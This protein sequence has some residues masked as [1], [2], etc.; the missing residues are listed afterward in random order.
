[1]NTP[2]IEIRNLIKYYDNVPVI[3]SASLT[4]D[5]GEILGITG[6][7]DSAKTTFVN[8]LAGIVAPDSGTILFNGQEV[9]ILS[10]KSA[11]QAGVFLISE[12]S[13]GIANLNAADNLFWGNLPE[14]RW[15]TYSKKKLT[16]RC[17]E[18][19]SRYKISID[20]A[21]TFSAL[22][23]GNRQIILTLRAILQECRLLLIDNAFATLDSFEKNTLMNLLSELKESG[24]SVIL[25]SQSI[26][27]LEDIADY[28]IMIDNGTFSSMYEI[29][30][31][32]N[33]S[34]FRPPST[35]PYPQ[36]HH[37]L[38]ERLF[39][40][41][42][43]CCGHYLRDVSFHVKEGEILGII[44]NSQSGR[45]E[46]FAVLSGREKPTIGKIFLF[47]EELKGN[48]LHPY[49]K[50][51][52]AIIQE[53]SIIDGLL[54]NMDIHDNISLGNFPRVRRARFLLNKKELKS[55]SSKLIAKLGIQPYTRNQT[56]LHT[57]SGNRQKIMFA[58]AIYSNADLYILDHP[59]ASIDNV[60]KIQIYGLLNKLSLNHKGIILFSSDINEVKSICDRILVLNNGVISG[61]LSKNEFP[62][63]F[64]LETMLD[65]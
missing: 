2:A 32:N 28:A 3:N 14:R 4:L 23:V 36:I 44:G 63:Y 38:G 8:I 49:Y 19:F 30:T 40:C 35:P 51:Q 1:M 21:S 18:I 50:N 56:A 26:R 53:K 9:N 11:K 24:A 33:A 45:R 42:N 47:G 25:T 48:S 16:K 6:R 59:T 22:S 54:P 65:S 60:G 7:N 27:N 55:R 17:L 39:Y 46:L 57:S 13:M 10:P 64:A 37:Q 43:I 20:P 58:R 29:D 34:L 61:E 41:R 62:D 5:S 12:T 52:I 15:G 31:A